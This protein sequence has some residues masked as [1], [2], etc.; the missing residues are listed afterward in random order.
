MFLPHLHLF[1]SLLLSKHLFIVCKATLM[2]T[3]F[4]C[5]LVQCF[6]EILFVSLRKILVTQH[7][8]EE[9][10]H[11]SVLMRERFCTLFTQFCHIY[12]VAPLQLQWSCCL[13]S[14]ALITCGQ[15]EQRRIL[16]I[17]SFYQIFRIQLGRGKGNTVIAKLCQDLVLHR[18]CICRLLFYFTMFPGL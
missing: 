7:S 10:H 2:P 18:V 9:H 4:T 1:F 8:L 6:H 11:S 5:G 16:E 14:D 12:A 15:E 3:V 13:V 17:G